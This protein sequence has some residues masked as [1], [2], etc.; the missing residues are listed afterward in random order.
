MHSYIGRYSLVVIFKVFIL[1]VQHNKYF[2]DIILWA[3]NVRDT[4]GHFIIIDVCSLCQ[5]TS[6]RLKSGH[7]TA[8]AYAVRRAETRW[9]SASGRLFGHAVLFA[10]ST[11]TG[12][13]DGKESGGRA[14]HLSKGPITGQKS[15][16]GADRHIGHV[17]MSASAVCVTQTAGR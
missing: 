2:P 16:V 15:R 14:A 6:Q 9:G 8:E 12:A 3:R 13:V 17:L 5:S 10:T 11:C 7:A 4:V 1:R